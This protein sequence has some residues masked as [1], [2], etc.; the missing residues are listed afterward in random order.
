MQVETYVVIEHA[1]DGDIA[2]VF[3]RS[4]LVEIINP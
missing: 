3:L 1:A 4:L 2:S